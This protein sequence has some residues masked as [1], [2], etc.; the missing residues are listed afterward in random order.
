MIKWDEAL[1]SNIDLFPERLAWDANPKILPGPDGNYPVAVPG[2]S[3][4]I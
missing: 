1:N 2:K 3:I 4:V